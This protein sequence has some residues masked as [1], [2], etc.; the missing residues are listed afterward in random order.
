[1]IAAVPWGAVEAVGVVAATVVAVVALIVSLRA[2]EQARRSAD[3]AEDAVAIERDRRHDE[4]TPR[5]TLTADVHLSL[6]LENE[7]PTDYRVQT[8]RV[9]EGGCVS[10]VGVAGDGGDWQDPLVLNRRMSV[11]SQLRLIGLEIGGPPQVRLEV[12]ASGGEDRWPVVVRCEVP[13][14]PPLRRR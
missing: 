5:M 6:V 9:L 4:L 3:A 11:G 7:G 13:H 12:M 1:M 2:K 10:H 8:I 14:P